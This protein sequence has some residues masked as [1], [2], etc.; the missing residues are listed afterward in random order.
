MG[1]KIL[2]SPNLSFPLQSGEIF[3][4]LPK[5][6]KGEKNFPKLPSKDEIE[7]QFNDFVK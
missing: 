1:N 5:N 6:L 7:K 3:V 4:L 2:N